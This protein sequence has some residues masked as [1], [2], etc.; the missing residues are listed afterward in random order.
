MARTRSTHFSRPC[1]S[2]IAGVQSIVSP[3]KADIRFAL[4]GVVR[5][6]E[7]VFQDRPEPGHFD[8]FLRQLPDGEF[9][10][11]AQVDGSDPDCPIA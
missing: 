5:Q 6:Q 9:P 11:I 2:A 4:H 8:N 3:G 7:P 1:S 10:G